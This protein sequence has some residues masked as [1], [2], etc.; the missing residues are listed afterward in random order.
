MKILFHVVPKEHPKSLFQSEI[1]SLAEGLKDLEISYQSTDNYWI[2]PFTTEYLFKKTNKV[3]QGNINIYSSCFFRAYPKE[4]HKLRKE[5]YNVLINRED[6]LISEYADKEIRNLDLILRTHYNSRIPY[7]RYHKNI[8]PW[9]FGYT[10]IQEHL[11]KLTKSETLENKILINY[12]IGH[13]VRE[14]FLDK[15]STAQI[16]SVTNGAELIEDP[17]KDEFNYIYRNSGKRL[18]HNFYKQINAHIITA[19]FGGFT[20]FRPFYINQLL[21]GYKGQNKWLLKHLNVEW[22]RKLIIVDQ[23]DSWRFWEVLLSN[24]VPLTMDFKEFDMVLPVMPQNNI[25]YIGLKSFTNTELQSQ[26]NLENNPKLRTI[27]KNGYIWVKEN[28][29]PK[30]TAKR[31]LNYIN[32]INNG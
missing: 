2:D 14:L 12:R 13:P 1:I 29:S 15:I 27:S 11:I 23:F 4:K 24:S 3:H 17:T 18:N 5:A 32:D 16:K 28:Y 8:K 7:E 31:F 20:Y 10:K 30:A 25:H 19:C 21:K 26:L 6:G 9:A 22:L